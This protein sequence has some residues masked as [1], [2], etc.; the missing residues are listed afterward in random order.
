MISVP[1]DDEIWDDAPEPDEADVM[2]EE[3]EAV[4]EAPAELFNVIPQQQ[5]FRETRTQE[6]ARHD[7]LDII[8]YAGAVGSDMFRY[9]GEIGYRELEISFLLNSLKVNSYEDMP[10]IR[11]RRHILFMWVRGMYKTSILRSFSRDACSGVEIV[12]QPRYD[13]SVPTYLWTGDYSRARLRGSI[14]EKRVVL[15]L[16]QRPRFL[17]ISELTDFL[18]GMGEAEDT[19]NFMNQM[20]EEGIGRVS[21]VKM[22]GIEPAP[23]IVEELQMRNIGYNQSEGIMYYQVPG[24][25]FAAT[26]P[27]DT[28]L[29]IRLERS[30]F[31]DRFQVCRWHYTQ[32]QFKEMWR[33]QPKGRS[34][35]M[36]KLRAMN[37][38]LWGTKIHHVQAPPVAM[39]GDVKEAL[40]L[41]YEEVER[42]KKMKPDDG[43]R[44]ARDNTNMAQLLTAFAVA[45]TTSSEPDN[46]DGSY[47][48]LVYGNFTAQKVVEYLPTYVSSRQ[49]YTIRSGLNY[50]EL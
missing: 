48:R 27:I 23:Q 9:V 1:E 34:E 50:G 6:F 30:G 49:K 46:Q 31:Y 20:L 36:P 7:L 12:G 10:D 29:A 17:L 13:N 11:L 28:G 14:E 33:Y 26:R 43:L 3:D 44:S 40:N 15:P 25:V 5:E 45:E 47:E 35:L 37:H 16:L 32:E 21:L 42:V 2:A 24:T 8:N 22:V 18:S 38:H 19:M 4:P 41:Q 39:L